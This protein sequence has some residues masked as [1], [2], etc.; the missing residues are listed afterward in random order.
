MRTI[1][2]SDCNNFYASVECVLHPE[3][4]G[5]PIAVCGSQE[6]RHGI[7][8]AKNDKAKRFGVQTGDAIWQARKKCP[9]IQIVTPHHSRYGE[10]SQEMRHL[11]S[12][13]TDQVE[14][15]GLDECWLD[16]T[17]CQK[18]GEQI[19]A[20]IRK[21]AKQKL[22]I[23]VS[24]GVSFNKVFAKLGSDL[25]KPDA[26]TVIS[27]ENFKEKLWPLP[28][29]E[30]LFIGRKTKLALGGCG[31]YTIGDVAHA[32]P[33]T[34]RKMFGRCGGIMQ[35]YALGLDC[36]PVSRMEENEPL[37]SIGNSTT[38]MRDMMDIRDVRQVLY[39]LCDSVAAR[40]RENGVK[41]RMVS[42]WIRDQALSG[43]ERQ[44]MLPLPSNLSSELFD[45]SFYLF[46][47][48]YDWHLPVRSLGV[49]AG[50]LVDERQVNQI[51]LLGDEK[52]E[53]KETLERTIDEICGKF[54][55]ASLRRAIL[56]QDPSL[57][58]GDIKGR[59]GKSP[60]QG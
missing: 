11:Y 19:A 47:M 28:A 8:L 56:L 14:P 33:D 5:K 59:Q 58:S 20:D 35:A 12:Q 30:L 39:G 23:T 51:S 45:L 13:Y 2:H 3:L 18:N 4:R 26:T 21:R 10:F 7:V 17:G 9:E 52:R 16:V 41:C 34:L 1:L 46:Q 31:M 43:F 22:G 50:H 54:G 38:T 57:D 48:H 55:A 15:F 60:L 32:D 44:I 49:R 29:G 27:P 24:V 6:L 25:R 37:K 36:S 40:L 53:R 42:L